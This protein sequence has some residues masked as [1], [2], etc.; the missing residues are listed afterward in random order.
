[1]NLKQ[2]AE[3]IIKNLQ[4]D[5]QNEGFR[6]SNI[7][8]KQYNFEFSASKNHSKNKIL[9]YFGKK[10]IKTIIQGNNNSIEYSRLKQIV[11]GNYLLEFDDRTNERYDEYI[12]TD[13]TGKGDF[14]G[15]LV[16]A[17]FYIDESIEKSLIQLNVRD[18]KELTDFSINSI[19]KEIMTR[20]P[21]NYAILSLDPEVY[22]DK[23]QQLQNVNRLLDWAHSEVIKELYNRHKTKRVIIDQ[24]SKNDIAIS[25]SLEFS[26]IEFIQIP[27]AEKYT[28]VAA[29]S[30]LARNKL[31]IW[32]TDMNEKGFRLPK[33]A[34]NS[35]D[36]AAKSLIK[37]IGI[38]KMKLFAKL[39]FKTLNKIQNVAD[40]I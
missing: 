27:K 10:G 9:T 36:E 19:A 34:S 5:I 7:I 14:F 26:E 12:G 4:K 24:F 22:N 11:S 31:N 21:E 39:H 15:P 6:L 37:K 2:K 28:G 1:M 30:I 33:G 32:Y 38:K 35:V 18:S 40:S 8:E 17:G 16:V 3:N 20:F 25:D 29:A 13:E 23:Y